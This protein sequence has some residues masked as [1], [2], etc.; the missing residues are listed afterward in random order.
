MLNTK[1]LERILVENVKGLTEEEAVNILLESFL[2]RGDEIDL[3]M[4]DSR[5][6]DNDMVNVASGYLGDNI[7]SIVYNDVQVFNIVEQDTDLKVIK[8]ITL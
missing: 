2:L 7:I 3:S 6:D 8:I 4:K 1:D 5:I